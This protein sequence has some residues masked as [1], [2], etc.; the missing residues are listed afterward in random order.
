[1]RSSAAKN[2]E[3]NNYQVTGLLAMRLSS[4][5]YYNEALPLL[6]ETIIS[7]TT[8]LFSENI[9]D[10]PPFDSEYED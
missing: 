3:S 2:L 7:L 9:E 8:N 10:N 6:Q 1:M 4:V 5:G